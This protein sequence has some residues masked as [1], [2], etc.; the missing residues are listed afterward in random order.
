M[1]NNNFPPASA[2]FGRSV[3]G[4]PVRHLAVV[5]RDR[6]PASREFVATAAKVPAVRA[7]APGDVPAEQSLEGK[8]VG[9]WQDGTSLV[10]HP[11]R[12]GSHR[13]ID[14]PS[15]DNDFLF[16]VEDPN[17]LRCPFGAHLPRQSAGEFY[18]GFAGPG[19]GVPG[20]AGR[21]QPLFEFVADGAAAAFHHQS[22]PHRA[23][24]PP[25]RAAN[26]G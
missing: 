13:A 17:G 19:T 5:R 9:R 1:Q 4:H 15:P 16:G 23:R 25:L 26:Q 6:Q 14:P 11:Q 24:R 21:R 18:P 7:S 3:T 12:P 10:R 22:P 2:S 8:M 20:E